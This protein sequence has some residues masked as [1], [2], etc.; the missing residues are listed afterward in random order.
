MAL[1]F[2]KFVLPTPSTEWLSKVPEYNAL[3]AKEATAADKEG[4]SF[5]KMLQ[6]TLYGK[7]LKV[8][9]PQAVVGTEV[10]NQVSAGANDIYKFAKEQNALGR[11][12]WD[13]MAEVKQKMSDLGLKV[14][15]LSG[16]GNIYQKGIEEPNK[17]FKGFRQD[18]ARKNFMAVTQYTTDANGNVVPSDIATVIK[19]TGGDPTAVAA[20]VID[21]MVAPNDVWGD[22]DITDVLLKSKPIKSKERFVKRNAAGLETGEDIETTLP[23]SYYD[24]QDNAAGDSIPVPKGEKITIA[25][26]NIA[27]AYKEVLGDDMLSGNTLNIVPDST[28]SALQNEGGNHFLAQEQAKF[29]KAALKNGVITRD[30]NGQLTPEFSK[31]L[32]NF[33]KA[34]VYKTVDNNLPR[35]GYS[36]SKSTV[37]KKP[38][39]IS[40]STQGKAATNVK[41]RTATFA[42]YT[43]KWTNQKD[44]DGFIDIKD[45]IAGINDSKGKDYSKKVAVKLGKENG[46]WV[47]KTYKNDDNGNPILDKTFDLNKFRADTVP[48]A[49]GDEKRKKV[50]DFIEDWTK[51]LD[52]KSSLNAS[53]RK[54]KKP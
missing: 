25:D 21:P 44:A 5:D 49:D 31:E 6:S 33:S 8:D 15:Q 40:A 46:K 4:Q 13:I 39:P 7:P 24:F 16:L 30:A 38:L 48:G 1:D 22:E 51:D 41:D 27:N 35:F 50:H 45:E 3:G 43:D 37:N 19:N 52:K 53:K 23:A 26:N 10:K 34:V 14:N 28:F 29:E 36:K 54:K 20:K 2:S 9:D 18:A 32:D 47:I 17:K 42:T 11:P 12:K